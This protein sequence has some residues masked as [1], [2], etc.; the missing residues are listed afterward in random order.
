[1]SPEAT[2]FLYPFIEGDERDVGSLLADLA[3]S[4]SAKAD[5]SQ[6][7]SEA[8][9]VACRDG[10]EGLA[11]VLADRLGAG[12]CLFTF[13]NGGSSTDAATVAALFA[14]P[15]GGRPL[16]A[17]SLVAEPA[18]LTA[19]GNDVGFDLVYSRQVIAHGRPGDVALGISTSG[20]SANVLRGL[21]E[22]KRRGLV[23]AGMAGYGGGRMAASGHVE[24]CLVVDSDS[25]HR[26]QEAQAVLA[27]E[28][29]STVQRRLTA[30]GTAP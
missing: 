29:W 5:E 15:P 1:M 30:E 25:V 19:L 22:A 24:H 10:I 14:R 11:A 13:G 3:R 2:D 28:V 6:R 21:E 26:I 17:R 20:D 27:F 16:R 9:L 23:T 12:A 8:T 4:A 18:V 7:V